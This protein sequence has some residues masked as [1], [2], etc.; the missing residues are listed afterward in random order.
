MTTKKKKKKP[1]PASLFGLT[2][3]MQN[4]LIGFLP[5]LASVVAQAHADATKIAILDRETELS[6]ARTAETLASLALR[7]RSF[8][9]GGQ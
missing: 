4:M 5:P 7:G 2:V 1:S 8:E 9:G 3:D 6:R